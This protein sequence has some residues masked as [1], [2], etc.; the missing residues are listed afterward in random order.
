MSNTLNYGIK[1][2]ASSVTATSNANTLY[3]KKTKHTYDYI[4]QYIT[5]DDK[6]FLVPLVLSVIFNMSSLNPK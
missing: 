3:G 1:A 6:M 5:L 4:F 2:R